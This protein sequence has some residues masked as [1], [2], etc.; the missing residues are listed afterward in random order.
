[1]SYNGTVRCSHCWER[2]HNKR[3]C[4]ERKKYIEENPDSRAAYLVTQ[5]KARKRKCGWCSETGHNTRTCQHKTGAKARMTELKPLLETHVGHVLSL[6]GVGRGATLRKTD[7]EDNQLVGV[8]LGATVRPGR[9][10]HPETVVNHSEPSVTVLWHDG[11]RENVWTPRSGFKESLPLANVL[12]ETSLHAMRDWG[13]SST[14]LLSP[15][16]ANIVVTAECPVEKG[17]NVDHLDAWIRALTESVKK[18]EA[19]KTKQESVNA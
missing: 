14:E 19:Y 15:S 17:Q 11:R 9:L 3:G 2:G 16:N 5:Q 4:P 12:G 13:Y 1:M 6:A 8:V 10:Y 18:C 7:W